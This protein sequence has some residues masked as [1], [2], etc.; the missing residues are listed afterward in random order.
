MWDRPLLNDVAPVYALVANGGRYVVTLD[1]W[2]GVGV[3]PNTVVIYGP[4]GRAIRALP[5]RQILPQVYIDALPHSVSSIRWHGEARFSPDGQMLI[6]PVVMPDDSEKARDGP[7]YVDRRIRLADG[8]ALEDRSLYWA[9]VLM[10]AAGVSS[11]RKAAEQA[12]RNFFTAPLRGPIPPTERG[13]HDYLREAFYRLDPGVRFDW[14]EEGAYVGTTV[15]RD[16]LDPD[17]PASEGWLRDVLLEKRDS[18]NV[19][20]IASLSSPEHLLITME[21]LLSRAP[22]GMLR[23]TRT[24]IA[25]PAAYRQRTIAI[26]SRTGTRVI[27]LDPSTPIPQ[28]PERLRRFQE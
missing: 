21:H 7:S 6:I 12:E 9:R 17:Y 23:G 11:T 4:A 2:H 13:W 10:Q 18:D 22:R 27:C 26:L 8:A 14:N 20:A 25:I 5:L 3:G 16:P 24:Y 15:L 1:E 28:R 19:A